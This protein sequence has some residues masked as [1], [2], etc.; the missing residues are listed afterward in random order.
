MIFSNSV[1]AE[2]GSCLKLKAMA[3]VDETGRK[4]IEQLFEDE[5][6]SPPATLHHYTGVRGFRGIVESQSIWAS[7]IRYLNDSSE[8]ERGLDLADQHIKSI[9]RG[10]L[11]N[12]AK[13]LA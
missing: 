7:H 8:Y 11:D 3:E 6:N 12:E 4:L 9:K 1:I 10:F 13:I 2:R 5:D